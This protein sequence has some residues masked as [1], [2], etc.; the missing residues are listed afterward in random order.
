MNK[1]VKTYVIKLKLMSIVSIS[2]LFS[3]SSASAVE[4]WRWQLR[5]I[6]GLSSLP[7]VMGD[8]NPTGNLDVSTDSGFLAGLGLGYR[9]NQNWSAE[10]AWEY[11]SNDS[12]A[13]LTSLQ[14]DVNFDSG[15]YASNVFHLNGIYHWPKGEKIQPYAGAGLSWVQ[16]LDLDLTINGQESSF[17]ADGD[18][19]FQVFAGVDWALSDRWGAQAELRYSSLTGVDLEAEAPG[20]VIGLAQIGDL[21]YQP[22]SLQ[23]GLTYRF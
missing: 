10:L 9:L 16:E 4:D 1:A 8:A 20:S 5:P 6:I 22:L 14:G 21:D 18:V 12:A 2:S 23:L 15:D 7:D 17:S 11:R 13:E 3:V 19:G